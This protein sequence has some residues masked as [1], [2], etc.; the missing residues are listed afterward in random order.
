M[1]PTPE[2]RYAQSADGG[3]VAYQVAGSGPTLMLAFSPFTVIDVM[4]EEPSLVRFFDRLSGF[5]R[6]AWFDPRGERF[7]LVAPQRS[8]AD[9]RERHRRHGHGS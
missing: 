4:W 8:V 1:E 3:Q 5:T 2:T 9:S 7:V 6:H